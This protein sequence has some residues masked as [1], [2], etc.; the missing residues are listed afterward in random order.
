M[1]NK[2][3]P[4]LLAMLQGPKVPPDFICDGCSMSPDGNWYWACRIHDYD[5]FILRERWAE[6]TDAFANNHP[7]KKEMFEEW[8]VYSAQTRQRLKDNIRILSL[9]KVKNDTIVLRNPFNPKRIIGWQAAS[10][11]AYVTGN[12]FRWQ[13]VAKNHK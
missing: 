13:T 11:Y 3:H 4:Y 7:R 1:K 5:A 12:L 9:Y 6:I 8:Y 10:L 2:P